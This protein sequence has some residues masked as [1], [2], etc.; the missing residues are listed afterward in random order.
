MA[1]PPHIWFVPTRG[2]ACTWPDAPHS[3]PKHVLQVFDNYAH[4]MRS[5]LCSNPRVLVAA[6]YDRALYGGGDNAT[7][8]NAVSPRHCSDLKLR[9]LTFQLLR[10][11]EW[12][13]SQVGVAPHQRHTYHAR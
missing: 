6:V 4:S 12:L 7:A 2:G 10:V 9:F 13:H 1:A 11:I 8:T 5:V 3:H